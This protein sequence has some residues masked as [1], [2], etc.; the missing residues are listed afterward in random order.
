MNDIFKKP[1]RFNWS[2]I[3]S[4]MSLGCC[5]SHAVISRWRFQSLLSKGLVNLI[6]SLVYTKIRQQLYSITK[7][8]PRKD[9][10][11]NVCILMTKVSLQFLVWLSKRYAYKKSP[12]CSKLA[13][14]SQICLVLTLSYIVTVFS[15]QWKTVPRF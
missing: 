1:S 15:M 8:L 14:K 5:K 9:V 7:I 2:T 11:S 4:T 10:P 13:P 12:K 3:Q 6:V